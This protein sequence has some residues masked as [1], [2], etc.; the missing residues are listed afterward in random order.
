MTTSDLA[1]KIGVAQPNLVALEQSEARGSITLNGLKRAADAMNCDLVYA[2]VP[3]ESLER[4]LRDRLRDFAMA[5]TRRT[6]HT[7]ALEDQAVR[8]EHLAAQ[9]EEIVQ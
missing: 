7:M 3:R 9:V 8:D 4:T 1:T 2:L 6:A 5:R